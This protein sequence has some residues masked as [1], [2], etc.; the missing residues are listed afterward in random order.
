M[1]KYTFGINCYNK[2]KITVN[3]TIISIDKNLLYII[4]QSKFQTFC[5]PKYG[6]LYFLRIK[7]NPE[8]HENIHTSPTHNLNDARKLRIYLVRA[9]LKR[10]TSLLFLITRRF[11]SYLLLYSLFIFYLPRCTL[12]D[13]PSVSSLVSFLAI[14]IFLSLNNLYTYTENFF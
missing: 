9:N 3:N 5:L 8:L 2:K 4:I 7:K 6:F 12:P 1:Q 13:F 11:P 14:F 10:V